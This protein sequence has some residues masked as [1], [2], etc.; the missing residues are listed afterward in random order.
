MLIYIYIKYLEMN[1][2]YKCDVYVWIWIT[3]RVDDAHINNQ[4]EPISDHFRGC[5]V[6][7]RWKDTLIITTIT[8][9]MIIIV[10]PCPCASAISS[11][12][13]LQT[14]IKLTLLLYRWRRLE[15]VCRCTTAG[16]CVCG[17]CDVSGYDASPP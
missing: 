10:I 2:F 14:R 11:G 5:V 3:L 15:Q 4:A 8:M 13:N 1:L 9:I 6:F 12:K 17:R 7:S 16:E